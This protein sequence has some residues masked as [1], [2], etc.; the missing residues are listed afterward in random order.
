MQANRLSRTRCKAM[1]RQQALDLV[2][3]ENLSIL[4]ALG[5]YIELICL[6][7]IISSIVLCCVPLLF[8]ILCSVNL[9]MIITVGSKA[10]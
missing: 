3:L 8:I 2:S 9:D 5:A 1:D 6:D 10:L 7:T 4:S